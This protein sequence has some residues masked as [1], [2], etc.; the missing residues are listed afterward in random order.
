MKTLLAIAA[1]VTAAGAL[2]LSAPSAS[3]SDLIRDLGDGRALVVDYQ[4]KPPFKRRIVATQSLSAAQLAKLDR[5]TVRAATSRSH[6]GSLSASFR[7]KPPYRRAV[8][9]ATPQTDVEFARFEEQ[10]EQD[11]PAASRGA[12]GK[13]LPFRRR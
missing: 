7:G 11:K 12:P 1:T 2:S 3:A 10:I 6:R 5:A 13:S 9:A 8:T 4:G